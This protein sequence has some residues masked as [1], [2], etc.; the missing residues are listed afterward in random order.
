MINSVW[1]EY[2]LYD[3]HFVF[4]PH[5]VD[6]YLDGLCCQSS[7]VGIICQHSQQ[8][9]CISIF[10]YPIKVQCFNFDSLQ[11][12]LIVIVFLWHT[13]NLVNFLK[14]HTFELS[15]LKDL[16]MVS[17]MIFALFFLYRNSILKLES[18]ALKLL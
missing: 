17:R 5:E 6:E 14:F 16:Q 9:L 7:V 4:G 12:F 2:P 10:E 18:D 13:M 11:L 3:G 15:L 1:D 8:L